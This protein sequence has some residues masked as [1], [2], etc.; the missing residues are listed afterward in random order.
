MARSAPQA[1]TKLESI[2]VGV[3]FAGLALASQNHGRVSSRGTE[4]PA[5]SEYLVS[6]DGATNHITS[7]A[8]NVHD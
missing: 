7:D 1:D 8:R 2:F 6:D 3:G 4:G 5:G